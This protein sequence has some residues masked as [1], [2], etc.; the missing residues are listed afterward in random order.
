MKTASLLF[1]LLFG[2]SIF[3]VSRDGRDSTNK[4]S[5]KAWIHIVKYKENV[6][7]L[8]AEKSQKGLGL[9][10]FY[11]P[12]RILGEY[13]IEPSGL[14]FIPFSETPPDM[15]EQQFVSQYW[16]DDLAVEKFFIPFSN[17]KKVKKWYG[18]KITMNDGKKYLFTTYH[19]KKMV[20]ELQSHLDDLN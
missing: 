5:K 12:R 15:T 16:N 14:Q 11:F 6:M 20:K 19:T 1:F 7:V 2:F 3:A 17:I 13:K 18:V 4:D 10:N 9:Y 8:N